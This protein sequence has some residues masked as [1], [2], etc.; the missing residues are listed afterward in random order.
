MPRRPTR[1]QTP[2]KLPDSPTPHYSSNITNTTTITTTPIQMAG[3]TFDQMYEDALSDAFA[4]RLNELFDGSFDKA[5]ED[6]FNGVYD[7]IIRNKFDSIF[8]K[9]NEKKNA[10]RMRGGDDDQD[11]S[12]STTGAIMREEGSTETS[13]MPLKRVKKE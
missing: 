1:R 11:R 7:K 5:F 6:H 9:I 8:D 12:S 2:H 13:Q 4:L 10:T 3:T